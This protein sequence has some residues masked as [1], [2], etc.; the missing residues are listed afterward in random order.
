MALIICD[1]L[2]GK[3]RSLK[4]GAKVVT[5]VT[6]TSPSMNKKV[7]GE[8]NPFYDQNVMKRAWTNGVV[9][10]WY[11]RSVNRQREREGNE[12]DFEALPH[13]YTE[14]EPGSILTY[15]REDRGR[16]YLPMKIQTVLGYQYEIDGE[17]QDTNEIDPWI[18]GYKPSTRQETDKPV[19]HKNYLVENIT[20]IKVLGDWVAVEHPDRI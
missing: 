4:K 12:A 20:D 13:L 5:L 10:Y 15:H 1:D 16:L 17:V 14:H 9:G 8:L 18:R 3:L 11:A 2:L 6:Y 7:N 19:I